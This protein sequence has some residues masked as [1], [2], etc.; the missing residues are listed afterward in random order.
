MRLGA[1]GKLGGSLVGQRAMRTFLIMEAPE[2][3]DND[4]GV[5]SVPENFLIEAF[6][7][8]LAIEALRI[9]VLPG[10]ARRDMQRRRPGLGQPGCEFVGD[11]LAPIV[12]AQIARWSMGHKQR[13][14]EVLNGSVPEMIAHADR[15]AF[16]GEF[17]EHGEHLEGPTALRHIE[18]KV[19]RPD[20]ATMEGP[21]GDTGTAA[22][23]SFR[24]TTSWNSELLGLPD[25]PHP[26]VIDRLTL[27]LQQC[28]DPSI[29]KARMPLGEYPDALTQCGIVLRLRVISKARPIQANQAASRPLRQPLSNQCLDGSPPFTHK[30]PLFTRTSRRASFANICSATNFLSRAFSLVSTLS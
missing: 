20:M 22:M 28:R 14:E 11:E 19:V 16:A 10:M 29:A 2:A 3:F 7:A 17:I 26:L 12:R 24:S 23:P 13:V 15:M 25:P 27:S 1:L 9:A 18:D 30:S 6:V 21:Q 5:L 4:L 8:E